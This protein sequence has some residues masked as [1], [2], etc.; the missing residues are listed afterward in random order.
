M[1]KRFYQILNYHEEGAVRELTA[2][3]M[4]G[5]IFVSSISLVLA[6]EPGMLSRFG[7]WFRLIEYAA[8]I[9]FITEYCIRIWKAPENS[10][11]RG[12]L[13]SRLRYVVSIMGIV[14]LLSFLP[15]LLMLSGLPYSPGMMLFQLVRLLKLTR[16]FL[17]FN[18]LVD[19]LYDE[20][21]SLAVSV[22]LMFI[23]LVFASVGIYIFEHKVQPD[24]FGSVP[25]A[26]WWAIVTL[27]TVG[28][29]D[30]TPV[31]VQGKVF[32]TLITVIGVGLVS[33]PAGIIASGFTEQLRMRREQFQSEVE[34]LI[35]IDGELS[36]VD[37]KRLEYDRM[38]LGINRDKAEMII[39]QVQRREKMWLK[40]RQHKDNV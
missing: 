20:F 23:I 1:G 31:T 15:F 38:E 25:Q 11:D 10:S 37:R 30:V 21:E 35:D 26:M 2:I 24:V 7:A 40:E 12:K 4:V 17:A 19:V 36:S 18:L 13:N 27:T 5:V 29:G 14:D 3:I 6:S 28:Y 22:I 9:V 34:Q 8:C 16:Y 33:L 32:A 39:N